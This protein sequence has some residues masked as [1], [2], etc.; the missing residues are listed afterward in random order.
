MSTFV[1]TYTYADDSDE[2]RARH[3]PDHVAFLQSLHSAGTLYMSGPV[4]EDPPRAVL[5]VEAAD[6]TR[7]EELMNADPFFANGLIA[8]RDIVEW[9]VVFDPRQPQ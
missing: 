8:R 7:I 1:V 5:V 3:R 2:R 9:K 6:R 4:V